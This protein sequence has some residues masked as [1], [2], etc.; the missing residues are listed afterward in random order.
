[1]KKKAREKRPAKHHRKLDHR[2]IVILLL[3]MLAFGLWL[4]A[5]GQKLTSDKIVWGV[6]YSSLQAKSLN[7]DPTQAYTAMLDQLHPK[8][9]RLVAYWNQIEK[10]PDQFDFS[11]L[12]FQ[13]Q[14]AERRG[15][16]Y[17]IAMGKKAP[18]WPECF[19][20]DWAGKLPAAQQNRRLYI[21]I[22]T[23]VRRYD[24]RTHEVGWQVENEPYLHFG[25]NCPKFDQKT[26]SQEVDLVRSISNKQIMLTDSGELSL[27]L[28]ASQYGDVFGTTLYR[29]ILLNTGGVFYH[30]WWPDFYTRRA[31]FI[32]KLHPNVHM[33][34]I[35][36][37]QAEPWGLAPDKPQSFYDKT[38]SHQQFLTNINYAK[39][40]G[41]G[42]ADFWGVEWWYYEKLH[43]DSFYW[44]AAKD[45]F[46]QSRS[47]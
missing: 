29:T 6:T 1:M 38:M 4:Y 9:L 15:I 45:L 47:L 41:F 43:G 21:M 24:R 3:F 32:K 39:Q 35:S 37:L 7:L 34:V 18:R 5:G 12:D 14:E 22:D 8:R 13:V 16:P 40:V 20:P 26:L 44:D 25:E 33:V 30:F 28:Q 31:N 2:Q 19:V 36:E 23:V 27:W 10:T 11:D 17:I 46:A 42:E